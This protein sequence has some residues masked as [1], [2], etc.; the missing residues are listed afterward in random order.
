[1]TGIVIWITGI[2]GSGKTTL[3]RKLIKF[4]KKKS[5]LHFLELSGDDLRQTFKLNGYDKK[6]RLKIAKTYSD[7]AKK[8]SNKKINL[9]LSVVALF[10]NIQT[11]NR[12]RIKKYFQIYIDA[13]FNKIQKAKKKRIYLKNTK[14]MWGLDIKYQVPKKSDFVI[15]NLFKKNHDPFSDKILNEIY[16][17]LLKKIYDKT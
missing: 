5:N 7:F 15:K 10:Q 3:S 6:S 14:N 16:K 8:I 2:P 12:L 4:L 11:L 17:K 13:D 9:C 1:M